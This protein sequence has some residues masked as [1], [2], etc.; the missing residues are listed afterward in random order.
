MIV[1]ALQ[2]VFKDWRYIL[3]SLIASALAFAFATWFPN[4]KLLFSILTDSLV[5]L[6]DK[7]ML[8]IHLL[9][10]I[11]T[12][13]S[14]LSASYTLIIVILLGINVSLIVYLMRLQKQQLPKAGTAVGGIGVMSGIFGIGCAAC[15]SLILMSI[16]GTAVGASMISFLPLKGGEFG[17]LGVLL[18]AAA[19]WSLA[20]RIGK[21]LVCET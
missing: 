7:L 5:P 10:S 13:F 11:S 17:I 14:A 21:P 2:T 18:L 8:P 6:A 12:N 19:T 16:F 15:G 9:G 3:L 4:F 20:K 1:K